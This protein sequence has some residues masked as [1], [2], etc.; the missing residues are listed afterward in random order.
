MAYELKHRT[1]KT[2]TAGDCF[3][4]GAT[5]TPGGVN[6]ALYSRH[7]VEVF[8]LLFESPEGGPTDVIQL[9]ERTKYIWHALVSGV[10]PGQLYA[11]KV[12]GELRPQWG[13]RFN[14][15]KLLLDPYAKAVTGKF[16]NT[17]NLLLAYDA[18]SP[19]RDLSHDSRDN[20]AAVPKGIVVDD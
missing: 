8:L 6:F 14:D 5:P 12:C 9:R 19:D 13:L 4:L 17:D 15:A 10:R 2:V 16:R 18:H 3:P 11:Y 1:A 7:A 20:T